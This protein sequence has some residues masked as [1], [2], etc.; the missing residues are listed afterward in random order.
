V[1]QGKTV[2]EGAPLLKRMGLTLSEIAEV[3]G[4][5]TNSVNVRLNEAKKKSQA[6]KSK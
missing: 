2:A 5:T 1:V 6:N 3:F 4:S